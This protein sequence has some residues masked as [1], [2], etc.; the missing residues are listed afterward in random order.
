MKTVTLGTTNY[1]L[2]FVQINYYGK[3]ETGLFQILS[4]M[5]EIV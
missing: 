3:W 5:Q 1:D 4:Y 2:F